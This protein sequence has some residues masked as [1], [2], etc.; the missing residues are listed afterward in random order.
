MKEISVS[1]FPFMYKLS[2]NYAEAHL[3]VMILCVK[4]KN[5]F[6]IVAERLDDK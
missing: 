2:G 4:S 6:K 5:N 1:M 3:N